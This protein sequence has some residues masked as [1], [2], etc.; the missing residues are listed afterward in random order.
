MYLFTELAI[1]PPIPN[2]GA[3]ISRNSSC[4]LCHQWSACGVVGSFL[5]SRALADHP[6]VWSATRLTTHHKSANLR[7]LTAPPTEA[8]RE[9]FTQQAVFPCSSLR[10]APGTVKN[11]SQGLALLHGQTGRAHSLICLPTCAGLT[12][13]YLWSYMRALMQTQPNV[14]IFAHSTCSAY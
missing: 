1:S 7:T 6:S 10:I 4:F 14:R 2:I 3:A 13:A 8:C 11:A 9:C 12:V 5:L